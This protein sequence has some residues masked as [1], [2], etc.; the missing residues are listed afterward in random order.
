MA[1]Q[2]TKV[3][4]L[5]LILFLTSTVFCAVTAKAETPPQISPFYDNASA[6][7][8]DLDISGTT[9]TVYVSLNGNNN[10]KSINVTY[11][12]Q[13]KSGS[14]WSNVKSWTGSKT[15]LT[16]SAQQTYSSLTKGAQYRVYATFKV[17]GKDGSTETITSYTSTYTC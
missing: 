9:A 11:S 17:T 4:F 1:I 13:Q 7:D 12:L 15:G 14:S 3:F 16:F 2:R 10:T 8:T 5:V 6:I